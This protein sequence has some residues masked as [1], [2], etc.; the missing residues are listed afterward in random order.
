MKA[1]ILAAG[2][3]TR[4][5]PL[6]YLLPKPMI[7]VLGRP[8]MEFIVDLLHRHGFDEIVVNTSYLAHQIEDYF[9]DGARFGVSM[10]YSFEGELDIEGTMRDDAAGSAGGLAR[11]QA[12]SGLFDSTFLVVCGDAIID[13]DL[14]AVVAA[15]HRAG[16]IATIVCKRVR[17]PEISSYGVVVA[18]ATGR[19]TSFQEKPSPEEARSDLANTGI[20]I[21]EPA[22]FRHI[23]QN[24]VYDIGSQLFPALVD[25]GE[26]LHTVEA[27]FR[28]VDIGNTSDYWAA[29][30]YLLTDGRDLAPPP[31]REVRPGVWVGLNVSA[32]WDSIRHEGPIVVG[33]SSRIDSGAVLIGPTVL[34]RGCVV[35]AGAQIE[36]SVV[37]DHTRVSRYATVADR[38]VAGQWCVGRDGTVLDLRRAGLEWAIDDA[39]RRATADQPSPLE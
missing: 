3:G 6:T 12:H 14:T 25:A 9:R 2:K 26:H 28:W 27:S 1:M 30:Q 32:D 18:D 19:V 33:A 4:V 20:Y 22:I 15:H 23:P 24:R 17:G 38:V 8:V 39:R 31:G 21:F 5:R 7:P 11:V 36:R 16:A 13:L 35:E 37:F 29:V 34:G 10:A